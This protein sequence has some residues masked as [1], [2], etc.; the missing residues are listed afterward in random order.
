MISGCR[1]G[2]WRSG[3]YESRLAAAR[4]S[5]K[6]DTDD[7]GR[8]A[9]A[10]RRGRIKGVSSR[11]RSRST[12]RPA[13]IAQSWDASHWAQG[14]VTFGSAMT[15]REG[16]YA[17]GGLSPGRF[18]V[19]FGGGGRADAQAAVVG[20]GRGVEVSVAR[21]LRQVVANAGQP[22]Q[23][24]GLD[25]QLP[26]SRW[27]RSRGVVTDRR[28]P[29]PAP[30]ALWCGRRPTAHSNSASRPA[31]ARFMSRKAIDRRIAS[32]V[33]HWRSRQTETSSM[34]CCKRERKMSASGPL[35]KR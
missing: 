12:W 9:L 33:A 10:C 27:R 4:G 21:P 22:A 19:L 14:F 8:I 34:S 31:V 29:I 2:P 20:L 15:D 3:A 32:P 25:R 28:A 24:A 30:P 13:G 1:R 11:R 16:Q 18:N 6:P 26:E 5:I 23:P 7:L 35:P 17:I